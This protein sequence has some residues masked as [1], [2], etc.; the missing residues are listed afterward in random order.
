MKVI[1]RL[2]GNPKDTTLSEENVEVPRPFIH[3]LLAIILVQHW[4]LLLKYCFNPVPGEFNSQAGS[5]SYHFTS[6]KVNASFGI[7]LAKVSGLTH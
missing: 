1:L 7:V 5:T 6:P 3:S 4:G 2:W